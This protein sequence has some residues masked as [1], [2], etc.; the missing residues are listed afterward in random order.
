MSKG[1]QPEHAGEAG[2]H[3][4]DKDATRQRILE[5][6]EEVFAE[7][8][9][10]GAVVDDIVRAADMSKGGFYFHFPNKQGIFLALMAALTP[11]LIVAAEKA[12]EQETEPL[13]KVDAALSTVI[14]TFSRHR[15]LSKILLIEAVGLGHGFEEK[16]M[17]EHARVALVIKK[18]LDQAS[19]QGAIPPLDSEI[20]AFAWL[21]AINEVVTRWLI[22]GQP[23]NLEDALP[24]LRALLL[25]SIGIDVA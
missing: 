4:R 23:T 25:R 7:K 19:A 15:R 12:I 21:G 8:G 6:A 18:Y 1:K 24:A 20:A 9:Y 5:A 10:H 14:G 11:R 22:T 13:A 16:L 17:E 2:G 3:T